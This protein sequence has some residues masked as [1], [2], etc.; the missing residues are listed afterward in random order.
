MWNREHLVKLLWG[1]LIAFSF[2]Y[3]FIVFGM[4]IFT[5]TDYYHDVVYSSYLSSVSVCESETIEQVETYLNSYG[6]SITGYYSPKNDT[7]TLIYNNSQTIRHEQCHRQQN[8][9]DRDHNCNHP[10]FK[11][12]KSVV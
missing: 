7:T 8:Y 12:R 3:F 5:T 2:L 1:F 10:I 11:D 6:W 9:E 4:S